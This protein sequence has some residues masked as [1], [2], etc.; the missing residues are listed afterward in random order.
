MQN[1]TIKEILE[2]IAKAQSIHIAG[3]TNPDGDAIGACLAFGMALE[4]AGKEVT[5]VL[6]DF[7]EKYDIIPGHHLI[8]DA[9][10]PADLF[11][12]LDT[13]EQQRLGAVGDLWK[14]A[15]VCINIDHHRSNTYFATYNYVDQD[16]SSASELV[17]RF[18]Q[19]SYPIN[20]DIASALYTGILYDTGAFRHSSTS[21]ATM[22]I[23][24]KLME[25]DIPFTEIY[26]CFFDRRSFSELKIMGQALQNAERYFDG[27]VT[28]TTITAAEIAAC[29]GTNKE[30]DAI[31]NYLR[32]VE[33][34]EIACFLYEKTDTDVKVSFRA[35]ALHD[36][37]ALS[38]KFGGGGHVKAAG[39]TISANINQAKDMV[40]AEIKKIM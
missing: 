7:A 12:A 13:A 32:G 25:Y 21:P 2:Q 3:H 18:L 37:C 1:N 40:L 28:L 35:G 10:A 31:V 15:G 34:T 38:Q 9:K 5:V 33:G 4:Q 22:H 14:K 26:D 39:C 30:L 16:A 8:K 27:R 19:D 29:Y 23:A 24:A 20:K 6:E 36:V 17:Y 11:L